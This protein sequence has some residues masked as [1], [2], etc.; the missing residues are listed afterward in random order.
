MLYTRALPMTRTLGT[1]QGYGFAWPLLSPGQ[2]FVTILL[3]L[4]HAIVTPLQHCYAILLLDNTH[5]DPPDRQNLEGQVSGTVYQPRCV[6]AEAT[7]ASK[8][9]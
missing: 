6:N 7:D 4:S 1:R 8:L 2:H 5:R 3:L 9:T